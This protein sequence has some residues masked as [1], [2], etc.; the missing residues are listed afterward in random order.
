MVDRSDPIAFNSP[1]SPKGVGI[2]GMEVYFPRFAV[3]QTELEK[4]MGASEGKFT[5]GLGQQNMAFVNDLEDINSVCMTAVA[6]LLEKYNIAPTDI[7]RLEVGTETIIDKSKSVKTTLVQIFNEHGNFDIEGVD[8]INA[9]YGGTAALLNTMAWVESSA[10][11]GRYA[12]VVAG[13]IAVYEE[14]PARPTG[15]CAAVAMLIGR[16]API[17]L[18]TVRSSH[19]EDAYDFYKPNLSSEYPTVFGQESN[20]C[21]LRALD[22]CYRRF[23]EKWE[24]VNRK[25][26]TMDEWNHVVLHSPYN[27]LVKKSGARMVYNDFIRDHNLPIFKKQEKDLQKFQHLMPEETYDDRELEKAF[28]EIARPMYKDKVEP[29]VLLPQELGNSYTASM[30]TGLLSLIHNWHKPKPMG[31]QVDTEAQSIGKKVLMFS[32][33]SGLAATLFSFSITGPTGHIAAAANLEER[34]EERKFLS[35]QEFTTTLTDRETKYGK[36]DWSPSSDTTALFPGTYYLKQVDAH[37]RRS[38]ARVP[39]SPFRRTINYGASA[40]HSRMGG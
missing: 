37:G 20:V 39:V 22:G 29:S 40:F 12:V 27:K 15:G 36:F 9:C 18:Q 24:A 16:D 33:G 4:F 34:L 17:V 6:N 28:T 21:Y 32:Y 31:A 14:G 38:Y 25:K 1:E 30:Y 10:W 7:G 5:I 23:A 2:H 11:D 13:D 26:L 8:N 19:F 35:P 3:R